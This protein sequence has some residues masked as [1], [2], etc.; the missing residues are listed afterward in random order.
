MAENLK[1][2]TTFIEAGRILVSF[3]ILIK[4]IVLLVTDLTYVS[5]EVPG[6]NQTT[7]ADSAP[8]FTI[9]LFCF[10]N[11]LFICDFRFYDSVIVSIGNGAVK[12]V[13]IIFDNK[14][15]TLL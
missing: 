4:F 14:S 15:G 9:Q 10:V 1:A 11:N 6:N 2:A 13:I 5:Q 8:V 7:L 12:I 3:E